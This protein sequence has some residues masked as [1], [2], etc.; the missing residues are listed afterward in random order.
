MPTDALEYSSTMFEVPAL[1]DPHRSGLFSLVLRHAPISRGDLARLA[2]L[3]QS[4]VTRTLRPLVDN[5]YLRETPTAPS[6]RGR[7]QRVIEVVP[8]RH[9]A[10]GIKIGPRLITGV[11]TDL[12]ANV[13][14][15]AEESETS[16]EPHKVLAA[17]SD[18]AARLLD[19]VPGSRER[20]LGVGIGVGGIVDPT[21][22]V[23]RFSPVLGWHEVEVAGPLAEKVGLPVTVH[24]DVNALAIAEQLFG[25]GR[26]AR[27]FAVATIGPGIG[28]GL[29]VEG[30]PYGGTRGLAGELGHIPLVAD[31]P[32]CRC[33]RRGCLEALAGDAAIAA[34]AGVD[35]VDA[36]LEAA[37]TGHGARAERARRAFAAAGAWIGRGLAIIA[38]LTAPEL[39]V[40]TGEG[41]AAYDLLGESLV[42]AFEEHAFGGREFVPRLKVN[43]SDADIWA[44]G[45]AC[46]AIQQALG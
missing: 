11:V 14:A 19:A 3:D 29:V 17:T 1:K 39:I 10:V 12:G 45:A 20:T 43:P 23:C 37:R 25:D 15:R 13:I 35:D 5:G 28:L 32:A 22:G 26:S 27:N 18:L 33:G 6:G 42:A 21:T 31:G 9:C 34:A 8:E 44:R 4:T 38:N 7:P 30:V 2:S 40:L 46:L 24:N 16:L 36:A 41:A